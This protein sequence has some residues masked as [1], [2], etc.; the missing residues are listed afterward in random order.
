MHDVFDDKYFI[1][2][3]VLQKLKK[4]QQNFFL[5]YDDNFKSHK[6]IFGFNS[7]N[8]S[9]YKVFFDCE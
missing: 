7:F 5:K 3:V 9:S 6:L 2:L 8:V 4:K 1:I